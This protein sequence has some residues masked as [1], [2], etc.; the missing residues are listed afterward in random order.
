MSRAEQLRLYAEHE[1][2][3]LRIARGFRKK[4]PSWVKTCDLESAA[5][6]GLWDAV[7]RADPVAPETFRWYASVRIRGSIQDELRR[8]DW[9]PRRERGRARPSAVLYFEQL[10]HEEGQSSVRVELDF[11]DDIDA[12]RNADLLKRAMLSLPARDQEI[13]QL[14]LQGMK[15]LDISRKFGVSEARISQ[16]LSRAKADVKKEIA[17][18]RER[19][20]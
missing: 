14:T 11:D 13:L 20:R 12:R 8:H 19:R 6:I 5:R 15:Q 7:S 17:A 3:A 18:L 9:L 1:Q 2:D 16:L 4:V 10:S